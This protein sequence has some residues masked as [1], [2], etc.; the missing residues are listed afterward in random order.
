V[1]PRQADA[2]FE[3]MVTAG[4]DHPMMQDR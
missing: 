3:V 1:R 2:K 4:H